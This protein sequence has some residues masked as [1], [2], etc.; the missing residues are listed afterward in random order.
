M[1][2]FVTPSSEWRTL[3]GSLDAFRELEE[4]RVSV[5]IGGKD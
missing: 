2:S 3:I 1:Y 5:V 4:L